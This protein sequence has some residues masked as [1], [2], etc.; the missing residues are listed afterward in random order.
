MS[1]ELKFH[2][3]DVEKKYSFG[4]PK[5]SRVRQSF[6]VKWYSHG[7]VYKRQSLSLPH[8]IH[9]RSILECVDKCLKGGRE[10]RHLVLMDYFICPS[11]PLP[12][13]VCNERLFSKK[14]STKIYSF[15]NSWDLDFTL[16]PSE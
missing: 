6:F 14:N 1:L 13:F 5:L 9:S 10:S 8:I 15:N 16:Q 12:C 2:S 4:F 3:F 7:Q 11:L